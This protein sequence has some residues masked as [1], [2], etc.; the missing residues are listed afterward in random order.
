MAY[1][2][3]TDKSW[4]ETERAVR[5]TFRKWGVLHYEI[6][7]SR[8]GVQAQSW[9]QGKAEAEVAVNFIH[10]VSGTQIPVQSKDQDRAVD[11]FRVCYLALEAIRLNEARGI[12]D[13]VREAYLALPAPVKQ[14]DP[15]EVLGLRSDAV[16]Q[17]IE[18][19]YRALAKSRHPDAGGTAEAFREVQEA[20]ER[21]KEQRGLKS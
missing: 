5:D 18:A 4:A 20:Y 6:L 21:V 8:R 15:W 17:V 13:V 2:L 1:K 10:P 11:N 7:S 12:S 9:N 19:T 3:S 14:R 16:P